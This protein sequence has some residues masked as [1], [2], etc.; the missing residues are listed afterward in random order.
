MGFAGSVGIFRSSQSDV[1]DLQILAQHLRLEPDHQLH[2]VGASDGLRRIGELCAVLQIQRFVQTQQSHQRPGDNRLRLHILQF[3][4]LALL[5][6]RQIPG[7]H[8]RRK[9]MRWHPSGHSG[10]TLCPS[11]QALTGGGL[12][13]TFCD[14]ELQRYCSGVELRRRQSIDGVGSPIPTAAER[15]VHFAICQLRSPGLRSPEQ[16]RSRSGRRDGR[17]RIHHSQ[18]QR[19][20]RVHPLPQDPK[21]PELGQSIPDPGFRYQVQ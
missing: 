15:Q 2:V 16:Q 20:R 4:R 10:K 21:R 18:Q 1:D 17:W 19:F 11:I 5:F 6:H 12:S 14:T 13:G 8:R 3:L 7:T 9:A